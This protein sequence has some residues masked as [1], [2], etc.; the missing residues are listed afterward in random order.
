MKN[1]DIGKKYLFKIKINELD[2]NYFV[3]ANF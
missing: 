2:C 1:K 3:E